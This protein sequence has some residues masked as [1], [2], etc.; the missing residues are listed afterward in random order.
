MTV[1]TL[2][3]DDEPLARERLR[4]LLAPEADL[5][6]LAECGDGQEAL[7]LIARER[8]ALVFLDVE[9]P[10]LDGFGV[11]A[12]ASAAAPPV[13]VF[14]TAWP[15]HAVRAFD[16]SAVDYLLKPFT[17]ERFQRTLARVRERLA[18]PPGDLR[19]QLQHLL[20]ELRPAVPTAERLVVK[21]GTQTLLVPVDAIDWVESAGNYVTLHVGREQ[22]LL[23]ETMAEL[24]ARLA[25]RRFARVHRSALVNVDRIH[26]LSPTLSG[27]HR[28]V[29]RDGQELTLSR[30][31]R[32]R[33]EEV[34]GHPL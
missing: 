7:A 29:L 34:L 21:S 23:R 19:Q 26:S 16:A 27:D 17:V 15:Q 5:H 12:E 22:H 24:E 10:E 13:V 11:L 3:V 33:L 8:P 9:M 32:A 4:T 28:L 14:V 30:T 6:P 20:Q 2:I 1:R 18:A 31:Y 25:S